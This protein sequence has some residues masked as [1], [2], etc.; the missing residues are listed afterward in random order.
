MIF[1]EPFDLTNT[2][3]STYDGE[4]FEKIKS[5]FFQSWCLLREYKTLDSLF[6]EQLFVQQ[7][8]QQQQMMNDI[9]YIV[10]AP[11]PTLNTPLIT[12]NQM[13]SEITS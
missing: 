4:I 10:Y 6:K 1:T 12:T 3:R 13:N 11:N 9:K 5:V 2:A 8:I 7:T